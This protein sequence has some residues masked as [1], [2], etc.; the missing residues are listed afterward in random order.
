MKTC[1]LY[2]MAILQRFDTGWVSCTRK[3][4]CFGNTHIFVQF[5]LCLLPFELELVYSSK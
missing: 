5:F 2:N 1:V 3:G 4:R